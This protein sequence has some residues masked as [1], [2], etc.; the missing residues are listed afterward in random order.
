LGARDRCR[1]SGTGESREPNTEPATGHDSPTSILCLQCPSRVP[2]F[3]SLTGRAWKSP[4]P[5]A[6]ILAPMGLNDHKAALQAADE[7]V[8]SLKVSL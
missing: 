6:Q 8:A 5:I 1:E 4:A 3:R 2:L 7:R